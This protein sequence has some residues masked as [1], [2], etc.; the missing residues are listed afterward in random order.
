MNTYDVTYHFGD[1]TYTFRTSD[2]DEFRCDYATETTPS[3][4]R[5]K[6]KNE[7]RNC[8][9]NLHQRDM[10]LMERAAGNDAERETRRQT[11]QDWARIDAQIRREQQEISARLHEIKGCL[12]VASEVDY[13]SMEHP[14]S[15]GKYN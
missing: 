3:Q 6:I 12:Y 15:A 1:F 10:R 5:E 4:L 2:L 9:M 8:A 11:F 7:L 14:I 13:L